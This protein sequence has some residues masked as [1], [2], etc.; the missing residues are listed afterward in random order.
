MLL[1]LGM[2]LLVV[3]QGTL[4][5]S[6]NPGA[7]VVPVTLQKGQ[8]IQPVD[9]NYVGS[10]IPI[11]VDDIQNSPSFTD[12]LDAAEEEEEETVETPEIVHTPTYMTD[13]INYAS[14]PVDREDMP[15]NVAA[16]YGLHSVE[17]DMTFTKQKKNTMSVQELLNLRE[18][19][20]FSKLRVE[21]ERRRIAMHKMLDKLVEAAVVESDR[22]HQITPLNLAKYK[23]A[24]KPSWM[25]SLFRFLQVEHESNQDL[26]NRHSHHQKQHRDTQ[27]EQ[28]EIRKSKGIVLDMNEINNINLERNKTEFYKQKQ[29][30]YVSALPAKLSELYKSTNSTSDLKD[31]IYKDMHEQKLNNRA[32]AN[33]LFR[34]QTPLYP[35]PVFDIEPASIEEVPVDEVHIERVGKPCLTKHKHKK[36]ES[37]H[38]EKKD[39]KLRLH[40]ES[41]TKKDSAKNK[42]LRRSKK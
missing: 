3:A 16:Y 27:Y 17:N 15:N 42:N 39:E 24:E 20:L 37:E 2:L 19:I 26:I 29:Q 30:E 8:P 28:A 1:S 33:M 25:S 35:A 5:D 36:G 38:E 9:G 23:T 13:I 6:L 14:I 12:P 22:K 11:Q 10:V 32:E 34:P 4:T 31:A 21:I 40:K 41:S 7:R 18:K